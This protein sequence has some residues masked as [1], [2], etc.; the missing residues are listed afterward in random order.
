MIE[1]LASWGIGALLVRVLGRQARPRSRPPSGLTAS[2]LRRPGSPTPRPS[3]WLARAK[4]R[5]CGFA[6]ARSERHRAR[7]GPRRVWDATAARQILAA[8]DVL[9][10]R[11][12]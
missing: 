7:R 6:G 1:A 8:V 3:K 12:E 5:P 9:R 11:L 2:T 4:R 10:A